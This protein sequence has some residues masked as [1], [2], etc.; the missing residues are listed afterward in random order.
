[1]LTSRRANDIKQSTNASTR[2]CAPQCLRAD[3]P[4][5][6]SKVPGFGFA[7]LWQV[8]G[9]PEL[10][11]PRPRVVPACRAVDEGADGGRRTRQRHA[12]MN[13][14][15][16]GRAAA[17]IAVAVAARFSWHAGF[18]GWGGWGGWG[19]RPSRVAVA[20]APHANQRAGR[21]TRNVA[22]SARARG[23]RAADDTGGR[24]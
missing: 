12:R 3:E 21:S 8:P 23:G 1:M 19:G 13:G 15:G 11:R 18:G 6:P 17:K 7:A 10:E 9:K 4:T 2:V 24:G 5:T 16:E 14:R 22:A 20:V